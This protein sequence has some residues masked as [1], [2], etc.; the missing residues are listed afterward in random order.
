M[1]NAPP[2]YPNSRSRRADIHEPSFHE[3]DSHICL[4]SRTGFSDTEFDQTVSEP[5]ILCRELSTAEANSIRELKSS[6]FAYRHL[7]QLNLGILGGRLE[8]S[9]RGD[10][11]LSSAASLKCQDDVAGLE[12]GPSKLSKCLLSSP[13]QKINDSCRQPKSA[14]TTTTRIEL[15]DKAFA[16]WQISFGNPRYGYHSRPVFFQNVHRTAALFA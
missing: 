15:H 6:F 1:L 7:S 13:L 12:T 3:V 9:S 16:P 8:I 11:R 14:R 2:L 5:W 4:R 10:S